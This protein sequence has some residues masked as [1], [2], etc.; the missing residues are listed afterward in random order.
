MSGLLIDILLPDGEMKKY[1]KFIVQIVIAMIILSP[2]ISAL[3]NFK[4][5]D[6][7]YKDFTIDESYIFTQEQQEKSVVEDGLREYLKMNGIECTV[8]VIYQG[9]DI[10]KAEIYGVEFSKKTLAK[11]LASKLL[12]IEKEKVITYE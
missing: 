5:G 7:N 9:S 11:E 1:S 2:I 8:K 6:F 3:V 12:Q 10:V 4:G